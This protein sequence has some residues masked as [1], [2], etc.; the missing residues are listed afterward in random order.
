MNRSWVGVVSMLL[1]SLCA[2]TRAEAKVLI[3]VAAPP[4]R[5]AAALPTTSAALRRW[6]QEPD[7][8]IAPA[9]HVVDHLLDG[10]AHWFARFRD[11]ANKV[12]P[13]DAAD[14]AR[15][16]E[17][18]FE[19]ETP[20]SAFCEPAEAELRDHPDPR[21]SPSRKVTPAHAMARTCA[22]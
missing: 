18:A 10:D 13:D 19:Y 15:L 22:C 21:V 9:A 8:R 16:F 2:G 17:S 14:W 3:E 6:M 11:A 7:G 1:A 4:T 5:Y 20:S 12:A